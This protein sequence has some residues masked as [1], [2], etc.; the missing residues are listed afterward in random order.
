MPRESLGRP[1][2]S[3]VIPAYNEEQR[4]QRSLPRIDD[5]FRQRGIEFE[6]LV[7]DDGST[8]RTREVSEGFLRRGRGRVLS[9]LENRGKGHSVRRGVLEA[10]GRWV[11]MTDADLSAPIEEYE[12]LAAAVRDHDLDVAMGSRA[13]ADS[14]IEVRQN[15]LRESMGKTFN[16]LIRL[17]TGLPFHD[18]QCGF[19][20]LDRLRTR[21]LFEKMAVEGFAFDVELLFLC[22]RFGL[23]VREIPIVWRNDAQSRVSLVSD[24]LRMLGDVARI[25]WR[26]RRG[27][28]NPTPAAPEPGDAS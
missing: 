17:A 28:Y 19:K 24:P 22:V 25:R 18:T 16:R 26:F 13:L 9:N 21:P 23:Q 14:R 4:L 11:L 1:H 10:G 6:V 27:A 15:R 8:D 5:Y 20:L 7:V 3:V 2:L 12:K